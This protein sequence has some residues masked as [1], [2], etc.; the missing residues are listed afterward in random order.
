MLACQHCARKHTHSQPL[1]RQRLRGRRQWHNGDEPAAA[2]EA[3]ADDKAQS[4]RNRQRSPNAPSMS[5]RPLSS[6]VSRGFWA[7]PL[8]QRHAEQAGGGGEEGTSVLAPLLLFSLCG[9]QHARA[10]SPASQQ[11]QRL[12]CP[13]RCRRAGR[14]SHRLLPQTG[15]RR[16][17][18]SPCAWPRSS[19][20]SSQASGSPWRRLRCCSRKDERLPVLCSKSSRAGRRTG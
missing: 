8:L 7:F 16:R 19:S 4:S 14:R 5:S 9:Q 1:T 18:C 15:P 20:S 3:L 12:P 2:A 10:S 13:R 17:Q 6:S 11:A